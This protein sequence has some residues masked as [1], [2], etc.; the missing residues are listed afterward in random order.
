MPSAI[1]ELVEAARAVPTGPPAARRKAQDALREAAK[2]VALGG[3]LKPD[4]LAAAI[5]KAPLCGVTRASKIL[6]IAA[7][8]FKRY[9]DRLTAIPV[10]GGADVF[11][12]A[13]VEALREEL[14]EAA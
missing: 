9:R 14:R 3:A 5:E 4:E 6:G 10:A 7:P 1:E 13:E 12:V 11:V 2:K 8:N